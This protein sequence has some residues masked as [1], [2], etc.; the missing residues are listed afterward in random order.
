MQGALSLDV[1]VAAAA[2]VA[3]AEEAVAVRCSAPLPTALAAQRVLATPVRR[4]HPFLKS[5]AIW[6]RPPLSCELGHRPACAEM[7]MV[8]PRFCPCATLQA[9]R[10]R[11]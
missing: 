9:R 6:M 4:R 2:A 7:A 10:F 3:V 1:G 11:P 5:L 8:P